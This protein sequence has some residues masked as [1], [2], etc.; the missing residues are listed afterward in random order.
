[1]IFDSKEEFGIWRR[2]ILM[3]LR[4]YERKFAEVEAKQEAKQPAPRERNYNK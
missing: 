3:I 2:A 1:M 4:Y